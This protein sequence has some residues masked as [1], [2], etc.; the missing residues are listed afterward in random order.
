LQGYGR[1]YG[2]E[3]SVVAP[4]RRARRMGEV[5]GKNDG[6]RMDKNSSRASDGR[7]E[8]DDARGEDRSLSLSEVASVNTP[9]LRS[10]SSVIFTR[11]N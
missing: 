2:K 4:W 10:F 6:R 11:S 8:R 5:G 9:T 3:V 1:S 7:L